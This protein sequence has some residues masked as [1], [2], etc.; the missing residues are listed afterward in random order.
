[1]PYPEVELI[2]NIWPLTNSFL[3]PVRV[4]LNM[5]FFPFY[6]FLWWIPVLWNLF[7][8]TLEFIFWTV[9]GFFGELVMTFFSLIIPGF[10]IVQIVVTFWM[11]VWNSQLYTIPT[12]VIWFVT[13]GTTLAVLYIVADSARF[14]NKT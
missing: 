6:F 11:Q 9:V 12:V 3:M 13:A 5:L 2:W 1:M 10:F 8:E 14:W 4:F 7:W